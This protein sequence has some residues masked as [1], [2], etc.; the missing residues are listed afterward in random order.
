MTTLK[1][2]VKMPQ[3]DLGG[4]PLVAVEI[5][6]TFHGETTGLEELLAGLQPPGNTVH[7]ATG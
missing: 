7:E 6:I 3:A 1:D 5:G 2:L 4:I